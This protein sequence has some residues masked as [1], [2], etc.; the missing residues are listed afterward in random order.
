MNPLGGDGS[1]DGDAERRGGGR[2]R[3]RGPWTSAAQEIP[4]LRRP[5]HATSGIQTTGST[6]SKNTEQNKLDK[7]FEDIIQNSTLSVHAAEF[8][9]KSFSPKQSPQQQQPSSMRFKHSVQDRLQLAREIPLQAQNYQQVEQVHQFDNLSDRSE[10]F[11]NVQD[12]GRF[13][14]GSGDYKEKHHDSSGDEDNYLI[15]FANAT[16]SLMSVI[17]SLILNPGRF[18][19]IVPPLI[20]ILRPYLESPSQLEE[21]IKIIIQQSINEGNFRYNGARLCCA[22]LDTNLT[23]GQQTMFKETLYIL[24]KS[25]TDGQSSNWQQKEEHT[26]D[27]QKRCHGLI[28]FLAELVV[29]MEHTSAFGLGDLLINL[30]I[31][32]LKRPAPNSVKNICQALKLAGQTLEKDKGETRKEME[33]MMRALT[34]LVTSGRVDSHIGRMVHSVHEL[35]NGNWGQTPTLNSSIVEPTET[36]DPNQVLDE[37]VLYGP[38]GKVLTAEENKFLEDVSHST[39]IED[40]VISEHG[41]EVEKWLSEDEDDVD[42][43]YEEFLK[44]IPKQIK[45]QTQK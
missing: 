20:N 36:I 21:I 42:A 13:D 27:E 15:E 14:G 33:N 7:S 17:H 28:L 41:Y 30:I 12:Y 1:G 18:D 23:P 26:E 24:C 9:P 39:I 31:T 29:Q 16:Q 40:Q 45:N 35:R 3:G 44:H 10:Y 22:F 8:I 5:H 19:V 11:T 4:M 34:E 43:A 38:D 2:G 37:P 6:E 25:E 32:V